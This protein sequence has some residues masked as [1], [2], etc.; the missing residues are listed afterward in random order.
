[1]AYE[2]KRKRK[3]QELKGKDKSEGKDGASFLWLGTMTGDAPVLVHWF[4]MGHYE[5]WQLTIC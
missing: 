1:M 2:L 5:I 3:N 4:G